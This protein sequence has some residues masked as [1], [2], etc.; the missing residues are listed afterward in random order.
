MTRMIDNLLTSAQADEG[1]LELL[2]VPVDL[3]QLVDDAVRALLPL[4]VAKGVSLTAG[5]ERWEVQAD[6]P[7]LKLVLTNLVDNAIKFSPP[8]ETVRIDTWHHD[9]EVGVTVTDAGPGISL[10]GRGASLRPVLPGGQPARPRRQRQRIGARDLPRGRPGPRR[11][12]LGRQLTRR[13]Q[14]LLAGAAG[15]AGCFSRGRRLGPRRT[16]EPSAAAAQ[17]ANV[18]CRG[19]SPTGS[20]AL[21]AQES[22]SRQGS[23]LTSLVRN[24]SM[25]ILGRPGPTAGQ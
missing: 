3:R 25:S 23:G 5:G 15:L 7:R 8:G 6:P 1:R 16:A 17:R 13:R 9:D 19:T 12:D 24:A 20:A 4:A 2:T 22:G 18:G 10:V 21:Q 14:R 11:P